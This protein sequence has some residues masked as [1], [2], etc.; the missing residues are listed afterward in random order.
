MSTLLS[1][2]GIP[3][4]TGKCYGCRKTLTKSTALWC[5]RKCRNKYYHVP[6]PSKLEHWV[7]DGVAEATDG[8]AVEPD[9]TCE[10]GKSSWLLV[11]G[12]I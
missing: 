2:L 10:H 1:E 6:C 5:N 9:G 11:L 12:F 3:T 8:C 7:N 4:T